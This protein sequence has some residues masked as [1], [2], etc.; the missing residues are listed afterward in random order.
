MRHDPMAAAVA[1]EEIDLAAG[2][3]AGDDGIAGRTEGGGEGDV[4]GVGEAVDLVKAAAA[5]DAY[6][7]GVL[8]GVQ[9]TDEKRKSAGPE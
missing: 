3:L 2:E 9:G 8:G 4:P 5:D 1:R 6:R 7:R